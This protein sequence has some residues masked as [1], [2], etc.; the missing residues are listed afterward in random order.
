MIDCPD[1]RVCVAVVEGPLRL[2][3]L[4]FQAKKASRLAP[5]QVVREDRVVGLDHLRTAA[6]HMW[7]AMEEGR[8]QAN[9][10]EVEFTRYLAGRRT[11]QEALTHMGIEDGAPRGVVVGLGD[12]R[13]KAVEY[14]VE[15]LGLVEGT[16]P[17]AD[18]AHARAF[19]ITD[20]AWETTT[21]ERRLDLP[22]EA[23]AS[24]DLMRT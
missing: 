17:D 4:L 21:G 20:D 6:A 19:G 14:F 23:V 2:E 10:P 9:R 7:R 1:E 24:V 3:D 13:E 18:E 12:D 15:M 11:I 5:V 16:L 22:L 8:N